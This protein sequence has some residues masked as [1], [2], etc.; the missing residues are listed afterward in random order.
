MTQSLEV[1]NLNIGQ[2]IQSLSLP[3]GEKILTGEYKN[4]VFILST[5]TGRVLTYS[6]EDD[7]LP[8]PNPDDDSDSTTIWVVV[9]CVVVGVIIISV[10]AFFIRKKKLM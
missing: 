2:T 4:R 1:V 8:P 6:Y 9:I 10:A 5:A 7:I 3:A